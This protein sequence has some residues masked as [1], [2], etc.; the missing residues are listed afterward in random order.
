MLTESG[1]LMT[2]PLIVLAFFS[3]FSGWTIALG[4]PI[5]TPVLEHIIEYGEAIS[6]DRR[7]LR[8]TT[9]PTWQ[10]SIL[11]MLSGGGLGLL[12]YAPAGFPCF[13]PTRLSRDPG[14]LSD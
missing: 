7:P 12:Y 9:M 11:I 1:P 14:L 10:A 2:W 5:T 13:V 8:P 6:R 3:I 4:L